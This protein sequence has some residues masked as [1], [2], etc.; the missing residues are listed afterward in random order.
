MTKTTSQNTTAPSHK[1]ELHRRA[2]RA[3]IAGL[4]DER[5]NRAVAVRLANERATALQKAIEKLVEL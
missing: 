1:R 3:M 2:R 5:A 4:A